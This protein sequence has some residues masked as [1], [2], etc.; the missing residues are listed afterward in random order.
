MTTMIAEVYD[1]FKSAGVDENKAL[2]AATAIADYQK[3][4]AELSGDVKLIKW[5]VGFNLAFSV[6]VL[7]L[8][9]RLLAAT[10]V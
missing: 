6:T 5:I 2:A 4:I 8:I 1:A 9:V 3:D 10:E 7:M